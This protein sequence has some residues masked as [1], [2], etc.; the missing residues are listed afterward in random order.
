MNT[1]TNNQ[2]FVF[3]FDITGVLFKENKLRMV[4]NIGVFDMARYM[5]KHRRNPSKVCF[6]VLKKM[7][8]EEGLNTPPLIVYKNNPMPTCI[9][10]WQQ[11]IIRNEELFA[12]LNNYIDKLDQQKY[13]ASKLEKKITSRILQTLLDSSTLNKIARPIKSM[14]KL[15]YALKRKQYPL[16]I[17][18]NQSHETYLLLKNKYPDIM[19]LFDGI[20]ISAEV[21]FIKPDEHIYQYLLATYNL[22]PGSCIFIDDQQEN[23]EAARAC[24]IQSIL[25]TN[26]RTLRKQLKISGIV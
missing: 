1:Q 12:I 8:L 7:W 11:G 9:A 23:I 20:V 24:G 22:N 19:A 4:R 21:H 5:L 25:Y 17:L 10:Q 6:A 16:Y 26:F 15:L 2:N 14:I 13:F 18:S 3:I